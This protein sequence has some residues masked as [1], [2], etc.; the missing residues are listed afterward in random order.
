MRKMSTIRSVGIITVNIYVYIMY[1]QASRLKALGRINVFFF[2]SNFS[3]T[4][5]DEKC[6][7]SHVSFK[8]GSA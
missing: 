5:F 2:S 7:F 6:S 8:P 1:I 3:T 4:K